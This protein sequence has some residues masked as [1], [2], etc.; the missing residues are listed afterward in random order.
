[1]EAAEERAE[2]NS[3][4]KNDAENELEDQKRQIK[5]LNHQIETLES[6]SCMVVDQNIS[7]LQWN[8][9]NIMTLEICPHFPDR[10][11]WQYV[12]K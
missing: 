3:S 1:M 6:K 7:G 2:N 11:Y 9:Y 5:Q 8:F 4:A 12:E 10:E